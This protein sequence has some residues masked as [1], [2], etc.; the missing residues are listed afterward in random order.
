[1]ISRYIS[2]HYNILNKNELYW[3]NSWNMNLQIN[4]CDIV[5]ATVDMVYCNECG[6][7]RYMD[8]ATNEIDPGY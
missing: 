1:M 2:C 3:Q 7:G 6:T 4:S 5:E 8:V